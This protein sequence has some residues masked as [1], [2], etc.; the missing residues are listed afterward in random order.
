MAADVLP[1]QEKQGDVHHKDGGAH[2]QDRDDGVEHLAQ[3]GKAAHGHQ[4]GGVKD[5][6]G[7]GVQNGA[8]CDDGIAFYIMAHS[9]FQR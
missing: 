5:I 8:Q 3:A 7:Q 4:V 9:V 6:I 1:A 2:R